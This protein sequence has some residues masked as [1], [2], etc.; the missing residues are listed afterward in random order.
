VKS[1]ASNGFLNTM[2]PFGLA[3]FLA[4]ANKEAFMY[5]S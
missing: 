4:Y 5:Y 1:L 2:V 3:Y